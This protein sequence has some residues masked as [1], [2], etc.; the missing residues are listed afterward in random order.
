MLCGV[1]RRWFNYRTLTIIIAVFAGVAM[2]GLSNSV[3]AP[4][5]QSQRP[6]VEYEPLGRGYCSAVKGSDGHR[7]GGARPAPGSVAISVDDPDPNDHSGQSTDGEDEGIVRH[8]LPDLTP[9][10]TPSN[11]A[12][13]FETVKAL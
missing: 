8:T 9:H 2:T 4:Q 12:A 5:A 7:D 10:P 3:A 13:L 1:R 6:V 11:V